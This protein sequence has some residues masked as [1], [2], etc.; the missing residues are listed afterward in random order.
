MNAIL[1]PYTIKWAI[2]VN[3]FNVMDVQKSF[4]AANQESLNEKL[5]QAKGKFFI[6]TDKQFGLIQNNWNPNMKLQ[7]N[8]KLKKHLLVVNKLGCQSMI[9]LTL[10]QFE[11]PIIK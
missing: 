9:P 2:F 8:T 1:N 3:K 11:N 6:I 10:K 4:F 7:P 5:K